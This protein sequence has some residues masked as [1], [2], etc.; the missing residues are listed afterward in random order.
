MQHMVQEVRIAPGHLHL[1]QIRWS[2]QIDLMLYPKSISS[3]IMNVKVIPHEETVQQHHL[4]VCDFTVR[5]PWVKKHKIIPR[6]CTWKLHKS[7]TASWL[8]EVFKEKVVGTA[9]AN[10]V[11]SIWVKLKS[12]LL[13]A[14]TEMCGMTKNNQWKSETSWWNDHI[15]EAVGMKRSHFKAYNRLQEQGLAD[16][17]EGKEAKAVYKEAKHLAKHVIWFFRG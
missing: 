1:Q 11:E 5:I 17:D 4:V 10:Q 13:E 9:S 15:S 12:S 16:T 3:A 7:A 2:T 8:Q 14:T 6:I